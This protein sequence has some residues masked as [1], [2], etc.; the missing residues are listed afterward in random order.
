MQ[1]LASSLRENNQETACAA[2]RSCPT[3]LSGEVRKRPVRRFSARRLLVIIKASAPR[4]PFLLSGQ[5]FTRVDNTRVRSICRKIGKPTPRPDRL[6]CHSDRLRRQDKHG[7]A[8]RTERARGHAPAA[9]CTL[10][11]EYFA[12]GLII[13]DVRSHGSYHVREFRL[14]CLNRAQSTHDGCRRGVEGA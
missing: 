2:G 12:G 8:Q 7:F 5:V 1:A 14:S 13:N 3:A 11:L 4:R 6:R 9:P 10:R